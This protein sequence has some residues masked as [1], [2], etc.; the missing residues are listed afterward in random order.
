MCPP[1]SVCGI[2]GAVTETA[3][4]D[5]APRTA[6]ARAR[7]ELTRE[8]VETARRAPRDRGPAGLSL[9]AVAR[10]LGMVSSAIYRYFPSRDDLL[11]RLII[12]AYDAVGD[13]AEPA[14]AAEPRDDYLGRWMAVCHAT[15][16]WALAHPQEWALIYG[17]ARAGLQGARGH[18]RPR[19]PGVDHAHPGARRRAAGRTAPG[20]DRGARERSRARCRASRTSCPTRSPTPCSSAGVMARTQLF[21]HI[22]LELDGQFTNTIDDLGTFFDHVMRVTGESLALALTPVAGCALGEQFT[23][24]HAGS[25]RVGDDHAVT[26]VLTILGSGETSPTMVTPHQK[27]LRQ[28]RHRRPRRPPRLAV[29][30]PGERRRADREGAAVLPRE[31]RPRPSRP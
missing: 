23:S 22:S 2:I 18:H 15:R 26:R 31:R 24:A 11:T 29:R 27:H 14:D 1:L 13:A 28:A 10:D 3:T 17:I 19:H 4:P 5:A 25:A 16:D 12:D 8:I 6:R 21:G 9:R 30:L 20:R 7:A